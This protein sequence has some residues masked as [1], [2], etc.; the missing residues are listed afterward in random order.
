MRIELPLND[1]VEVTPLDPLSTVHMQGEL[2]AGF[3]YS[4][5]ESKPSHSDLGFAVYGD[6]IV[7]DRLAGAARLWVRA[8]PGTPNNGAVT[9]E[10]R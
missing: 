4:Q 6:A 1:W 3:M 7:R 8:L 2:A 10:V 5:A 9:V